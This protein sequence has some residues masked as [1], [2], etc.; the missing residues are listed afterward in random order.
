MKLWQAIK[1]A[2][3]A[4]ASNKMRAFLTMLGIIIGVLSVTVLIAIGQG[5]TVQITERITALGTNIITV[6]NRA[7]R[8]VRLELKDLESLRGKGAVNCVA[9]LITSSMTLKAGT[10][11]Y[12][13]Q[14]QG[15]T[16]G[17]D[18]IRGYGIQRGR[19]ITASD[20]HGRSYVCVVGVTVADE[21]FGQRN[22]VGEKIRINGMQYSIVGLFEE[23]GTDVGASQDECVAIPFTNA[24]RSFRNTAIT[25][26][27]ANA[28]GE[29]YVDQAVKTLEAF[30]LYKTGNED[31]Y[32][33]TS[34]TQLLES[35]AEVSNTLSLM[36]GGIAAI[37]LLVG[38]IGIMNIMLVSV[39]ERTREIGIRKAIGARRTD[40]MMQFIIEAIVL[41]VFGGLVGILLAWFSCTTIAPRIGVA[42]VMSSQVAFLALLFSVFIGVLFGS[43]PAAKASRLLPID[44]LR[45]E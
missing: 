41:S 11:T 31:S 6:Q 27:Y 7:V 32:A 22:V 2:F 24:Q 18:I 34:Q 20:V 5:S 14:V 12:T 4:I 40:I 13:A 30:M 19:F 1:M 17:Y 43:Y 33:V 8:Q 28:Y 44:A 9:P 16:E 36:L 35:M 3:K 26:F 25:T 15:T 21:L 29:E 38:G 37:S 42:M 45:Y 39:S 10:N 23:M